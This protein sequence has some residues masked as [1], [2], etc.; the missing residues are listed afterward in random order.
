MSEVC[1]T[2]C[3]HEGL[4]ACCAIVCR[5]FCIMIQLLIICFSTLWEATVI[6]FGLDVFDVCQHKSAN[7]VKRFQEITD[8][9]G[10]DLCSIHCS[11][12]LHHLT[13]VHTLLI[14]FF[15][16]FYTQISFSCHFYTNQD[17]DMRFFVT[18]SGHRVIFL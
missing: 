6:L 15:F 11:H 2:D 1:T 18:C 3:L 9:V 17:I 14:P 7:R 12:F 5:P 4:I 16:F 13:H 10:N 8:D